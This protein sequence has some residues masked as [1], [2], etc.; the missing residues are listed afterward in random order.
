[1]MRRLSGVSLDV[2]NLVR[3]RGA[4]LEPRFAGRDFF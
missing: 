2:S 3:S 1:M 4:R